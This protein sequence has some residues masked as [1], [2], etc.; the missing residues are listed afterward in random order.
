MNGVVFPGIPTKI[1]LDLIRDPCRPEVLGIDEDVN[2]LSLGDHG[3]VGQPLRSDAKRHRGVAE[4]LD[5]DAGLENIAQPCRRLEVHLEPGSDDVHPGAAHL[6]A[7]VAGLLEPVSEG[8]VP[9]ARVVPVEDDRLRITIRIPDLLCGDHGEKVPFLAV[10]T[11][12]IDGGPLTSEQVVAVALGHADVAAADD[13][14]AKLAPAR[15]V[16]DE[17]VDS[18]Q[19]VYG[20]TTGFGALAT[21]HI[22]RSEAETLQYNL[23]RSHATGVGEPV[24]DEVVRA[25]LLL[26]ARTL[27]QGHSGVR[28]VIV[29]KLLELLQRDILPVVPSQGSVGASGDL[30]PFAHLALPLI[31]EGEV[32]VGG[33]VIDASEAAFEPIELLTKEGLSLLNGTEGMSAMGAIALHHARNLVMAADAA[34]ALSVEAQLGSAR[35][36]R[37]EIH[38][39]RPHRGQIDSAKRIASL[40]EGSGII[41][42]HSDDFQHA[43]QDAYSLRCAPQVHGAVADTLDH[44]SS[45][46]SVEMGSLVDN[47]IVFADSGEVLSGGNFHG[48]PLALVSDFAAI[49]VSELASISERRTDRMLDPARSEGLPPFLAAKPGVES[50]Y[51]I[52]QY[53]QAALVAENRVLAHP[54]S[55]D[56]VPTSG[57]QEDHVSMG[58]G[59][60]KKLLTVIENVRRVI[61]IEILCAVEAIGHRAPLTPATGTDRLVGAVRERAPALKGDRSHSDDIE[62]V[63][64][65]IETGQITSLTQ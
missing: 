31:G 16:V 38:E 7:S 6:L 52:T 49:A 24:A 26:R 53:V 51:M 45:V 42:S 22:G 5:D 14:D 35:P 54:A 58:W 3:P 30:A 18:D 60:A 57:G 59:A 10:E 48:E 47:P 15:R 29:H 50:G 1:L 19:V 40:I 65:M 28:P 9:V 27:S 23:L 62:A 20:I 2:A 36:F 61:A 25:M 34:A 12:I 33:E 37:P 41:A 43:V 8:V 56:S 39:L 17:A 64:R 11:V 63:A 55:V 44:M 4:A 32:R 13:L 46:L 21:T